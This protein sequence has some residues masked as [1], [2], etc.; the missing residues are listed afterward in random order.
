M[1]LFRHPTSVPSYTDFYIPIYYAINFQLMKT[2]VNVAHWIKFDSKN[3][4]KYLYPY[5]FFWKCRDRN[6]R[7]MSKIVISLVLTNEKSK[8][9][10]FVNKWLRN[11]NN[12][13]WCI[14]ISRELFHSSNQGKSIKSAN[15]GKR[16]VVEIWNWMMHFIIIPNSR[17]RFC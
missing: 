3:A 1:D 7:N 16:V 12:A 8:G 6:L 14:L 17:I 4:N 9:A 11:K 2:Q 5:S 10:S 15:E 13:D